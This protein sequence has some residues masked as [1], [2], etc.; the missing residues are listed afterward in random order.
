MSSRVCVC[1]YLR[2]CVLCVYLFVCVCARLCMGGVI[3]A[4][5]FTPPANLT[6]R[7]ASVLCTYMH[8][9]ACF[10]FTFVVDRP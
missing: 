4:P 9:C 6:S 7:C 8:L 5:P 1:V 3:S 10:M 2:V